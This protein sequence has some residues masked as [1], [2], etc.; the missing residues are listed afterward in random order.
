MKNIIVITGGAGFVGSNLIKSLL[1]FISNCLILVEGEID[2]KY[3]K[4][5]KLNL[6]LPVVPITDMKIKNSDLVIATQGRAF[7]IFDDLN[8]IRQYDPQNKEGKLFIPEETVVPNWYS[9]MNSN[10]AN[11]TD[12]LEGV[13]PASGMVLYY[14]L[15]DK[16]ESKEVNLTISDLNLSIIKI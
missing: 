11:G 2:F 3:S 7:W 13:N 5:S 14:N 12:L 6:N 10:S 9:S 1:M 8:V 16:I 4:W 15:P